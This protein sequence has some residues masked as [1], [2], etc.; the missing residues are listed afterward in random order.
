MAKDW[1]QSDITIVD[2]TGRRP[3]TTD[4]RPWSACYEAAANTAYTAVRRAIAAAE[5]DG[6]DTDYIRAAGFDRRSRGATVVAQLWLLER[7]A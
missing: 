7:G 6:W 2:E 1:V 5:V 4:G 3:I